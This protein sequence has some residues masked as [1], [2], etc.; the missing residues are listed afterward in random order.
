MTHDCLPNSINSLFCNNIEICFLTSTLQSSL[1]ADKDIFLLPSPCGFILHNIS[2][3]IVSLHSLL[4]SVPPEEMSVL[5]VLSYKNHA[6]L[7][8][9]KNK[10]K[11]QPS[12]WIFFR[13]VGDTRDVTYFEMT[14][15]VRLLEHFTSPKEAYP[16][17]MR[18]CEN[19][20]HNNVL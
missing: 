3:L 17:S 5:E 7:N 1:K 4:A 18:Q 15:P 9:K 20:A 19:S 13:P 16:K 10:S 8:K 11:T 2:L 14:P 6:Q 12:S